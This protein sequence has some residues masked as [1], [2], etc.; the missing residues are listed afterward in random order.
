VRRLFLLGALAL[1]AGCVARHQRPPEPTSEQRLLEAITRARVA[2]SAGQ[3]DEAE[4]ILTRFVNANPSTPQAREAAYWRAVL[5]LESA[6]SQADRTEAKRD[7]AAYL[8]DTT[9]TAHQTEARI[10]QNLL[11]AVDAAT[12]ASDSA[13]AAARQAATAR[14]EELKKEIQSLREQLEKTNDELERIK[15]RLGA[16]P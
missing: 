11:T 16:R 2:A 8:A 5:R 7:L 15:R 3:H 1:F 10:I 14:E 13:N 12:H 4:A 6:I 9:M